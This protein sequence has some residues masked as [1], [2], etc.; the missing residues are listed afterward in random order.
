[1]TGNEY[2][3]LASRTLELGSTP[4]ISDVESKL[5]LAALG[6]TG[7]SGEVA[8]II[9]KA[10]FHGHTLDQEKIKQELGD[11]L[12]Y[13]AATATTL[14]FELSE[15]MEINIQKLKERY[16]NGFNSADSINRKE[17]L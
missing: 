5:C 6:L 1:M 3:K 2:Q 13:I 8:D 14:G 15:I 12:W 11:I 10:V 4:T 7:E 17:I 9:K 16:P